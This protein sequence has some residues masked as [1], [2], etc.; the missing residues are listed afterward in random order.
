[1][2]YT[3]D[4]NGISFNKEK[5]KNKIKDNVEVTL[6][7]SKNKEV[8]YAFRF[9][10]EGKEILIEDQ[11]TMDSVRVKKK[12]EAIEYISRSILIYEKF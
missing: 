6:V 8:N 2:K 7:D 9:F 4:D 11:K 12:K 1:M 5:L 3:I 10:L